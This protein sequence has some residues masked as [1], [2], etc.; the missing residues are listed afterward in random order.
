MH[1][2]IKSTIKHYLDEKYLEQ[3][4]DNTDYPMWQKSKL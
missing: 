4:S 1:E 2:N 3:L